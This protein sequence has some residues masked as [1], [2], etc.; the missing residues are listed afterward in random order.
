MSQSLEQIDLSQIFFLDIETVSQSA[1]FNELDEE[2]Q[3]LWA[4]K[5][6]WQ[7]KDEISAE[8]FYP[9]RAGILAEFAKVACVS[10]GF[11]ERVDGHP[12]RFRVTSFYGKDEK[13][14]LEELS[15]PLSRHQYLLCAH[16]GKEF[17]FPFLAR[18]YVING[19]ELPSPLNIQGK[20]PW[21]IQHLDTMEL[22]KF[23]DYKHFTS[24][25]LLSK[26]LGIPSPKEDIDGSQV[27]E[28]FWKDDD[29]ERI[30]RYCER[31]TVTVAQVLLRMSR[32]PILEEDEIHHV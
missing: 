11:F 15:V 29:L 26:C 28:V 14:I 20:K 32:R 19:L 2:W 10:I 31:D 27:G 12:R 3:A 16:N 5:T 13:Q 23:G 9:Q 1:S 17:D 7:R 18:R 24:L 25:K 4:D 6:R 8:E 30:A 21:E 22:W